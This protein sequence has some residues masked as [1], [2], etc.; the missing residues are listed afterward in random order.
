[1]D[2]NADNTRQELTDEQT[3]D[4]LSRDCIKHQRFYRRHEKQDG[5]KAP[6]TWRT[7]QD[8]FADVWDGLQ[9]RLEYNPQETAAA[10]LR[11]WIADCP[12]KFHPG[13]RRTLQRRISDW[14]QN[15]KGHERKMNAVML[16]ESEQLLS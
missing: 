9:S 7:R 2:V 15:S 16:G 11:E 13:H 1:M 6:R 8:P 14:R 3:S 12:D 5:G 10:L 4:T